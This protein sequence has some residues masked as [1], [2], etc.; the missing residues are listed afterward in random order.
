MQNNF[1][2]VYGYSKAESLKVFDP[3]LN[4]T[5]VVGGNISESVINCTLTTLEV[6]DWGLRLY[7]SA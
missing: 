4:L 7:T 2:E 5:S 6:Y 1:T 3:W